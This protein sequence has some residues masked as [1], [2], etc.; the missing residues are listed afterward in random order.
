MS[1]SISTM[2]LD[3]AK[4]YSQFQRI[5]RTSPTCF[6]VVGS[7]RP[8]SVTE[9]KTGNNLDKHNWNMKLCDSKGGLW[10]RDRE[11]PKN[12][13]SRFGESSSLPTCQIPRSYLDPCLTLIQKWVRLAPAELL[14][15]LDETSLSDSEGKK[16]KPGRLS[17]LFRHQHRNP[18]LDTPLLDIGIRGCGLPFA[19]VLDWKGIDFL[20]IYPGHSYPDCRRQSTASGDN[21]TCCCYDEALQELATYG[22]LLIK[23]G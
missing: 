16:R 9:M 23:A 1:L 14:F 17:S 18:S 7:G 4:D 10:F 12:S 20:R 13:G 15:N 19:R 6:P 3:P 22:V 21:C 5:P 8:Y 2:I 11:I